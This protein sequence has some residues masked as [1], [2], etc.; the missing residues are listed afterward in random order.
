MR[1]YIVTITISVFL[2]LLG[3]ATPVESAPKT[4][5]VLEDIKFTW[6]PPIGF[7]RKTTT[8]SAGTYTYIT[9][10]Y[11]GH[12]Y[13]S[14]NGRVS[15]AVSDGKPIECAGG[16]GI[17]K[18]HGKF[19]VWNASKTVE[20]LLPI[21]GAYLHGEGGRDAYPYIGKIPPELHHKLRVIP[22]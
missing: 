7:P 6:T 12:I 4:I 3:C 8:L 5:V 14:P 19:Y 15:V 1:K 22:R 10:N 20:M 11:E 9:T 2:S 16:I 18:F 13:S 17:D 21:G